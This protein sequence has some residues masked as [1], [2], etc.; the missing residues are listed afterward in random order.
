MPPVNIRSFV[1]GALTIGALAIFLSAAAAPPHFQVAAPATT[2]EV[3][4]A[5][6]SDHSI[7]HYSVDTTLH[8]VHGSFNL[9]SGT[10]HFNPATG[11]AGG[12]IIV[13]ATSG[14]SG[15]EKRDARMHKEILETEK[16][17][18][19]VFQPTQIEGQVAPT[20]PSDVKLH[21]ILSLHGA[22]HDITARVH[23]ELSGVRW[24]GTAQFEVPYIAWGIKDPSN[25]LLKVKKVVNV[26]L[27]MS[28]T[29]HVP[30]ATP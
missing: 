13:A 16:F 24:K 10:L 28:G 25:F 30:S 8:T 2:T 18:D 19:A 1:I 7:A 12:Q 9:K 17:P 5:V 15:N 6:D 27:E 26:E 29:M 23:A 14:D 21:G 3:V 22:D 20:G 4:L 11:K